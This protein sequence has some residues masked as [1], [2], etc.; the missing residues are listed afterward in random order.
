VVN[1]PT[2]F[3]ALLDRRDPTRQGVL[4]GG[5]RE[6][7]FTLTE[8]ADVLKTDIRTVR[9]L[10]RTKALRAVLISPRVTRVSEQAIGDYL[11]PPTPPI[12]R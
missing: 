2:P 8:V 4:P 11:N 3:P 6:Y 9:K 7:C 10:I 12:R 5:R 1:G